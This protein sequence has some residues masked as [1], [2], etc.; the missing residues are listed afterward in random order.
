MSAAA[1]KVRCPSCGTALRCRAPATPEQTVKCP[2]CGLLFALSESLPAAAD[3]LADVGDR[4]QLTIDLPAASLT[5]PGLAANERNDNTIRLPADEEEEGEDR[6]LNTTGAAPPPEVELTDTIRLEASTLSDGDE[7]EE[8][9][10]AS[11]SQRT[12]V[13]EVDEEAAPRRKKRRERTEGG[14]EW[15]KMIAVAAAVVLVGGAVAAGVWY[16]GFR[17]RQDKP[18]TGAA[19]RPPDGGKPGPQPQGGQPLLPLL[20]ER[21]RAVGTEVG[22]LAPEI[23][24][25]MLSGMAYNLSDFRGKVVLLDF[26]GDWCPF[27]RS[28]YSVEK[29]LVLKLGGRPFVMLG[30]NS[31][32][33]KDMARE[34]VRRDELNWD[35][36]YD[37]RRG[38]IADRWEIGSFPTFFLIDHTG[39]IRKTFKGADKEE[40]QKLFAEAEE[41]VRDA[42]ASRR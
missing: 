21:N 7:E 25:E 35:S 18:P 3:S 31:D 41:L 40:L 26:W 10:R 6:T 27:C 38:A 2:R 12:V 4:N 19:Q 24:G 23:S 32:P 15:G 28:C 29:D 9:R 17:D 14:V 5:A 13:V 11:K 33:T 20:P 30:V 42:E 1:T 34:A 8:R 36:W 39:V 22:N 16:F 37:G